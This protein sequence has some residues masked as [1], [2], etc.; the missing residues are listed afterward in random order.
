[1]KNSTLFALLLSLLFPAIAAE[2]VALFDGKTFAGW[3]GNVDSVWRIE[4]GAL[5][6][7]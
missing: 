1:M 3:E 4:E 7:G 2:S 5:V 6:A